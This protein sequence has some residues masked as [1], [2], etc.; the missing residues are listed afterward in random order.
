MRAYGREK[1]FSLCRIVHFHKPAVI[2]MK[3]DSFLAP[4]LIGNFIMDDVNDSRSSF[5]YHYVDVKLSLSRPSSFFLDSLFLVFAVLVLLAAFFSLMKF[6]KTQKIFL[7]SEKYL[8]F[9][10]FFTHID[11]KNAYER[12][13]SKLST[14]C[15]KLKVFRFFFWFFF[16]YLKILKYA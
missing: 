8:E 13:Q 16:Q 15:A 10:Y 11:K 9:L 14:L 12:F 6:I 5:S 3:K 7:L 1:N 2:A 4:I